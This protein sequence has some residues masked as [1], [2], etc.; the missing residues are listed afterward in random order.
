MKRLIIIGILIAV[1]VVLVAAPALSYGDYRSKD[2]EL[3]ITVKAYVA[4]STV[5]I[6]VYSY[7]HEQRDYDH[8]SYLGYI[9][10]YWGQV[11]HLAD[12]SPSYPFVSVVVA[13]M[14]KQPNGGTATVRLMP[15]DS[16]G[17]T[18][19]DHF[20]KDY[21]FAVRPGDRIMVQIQVV[22][23]SGTDFGYSHTEFTV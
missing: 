5:G 10:V 1:I 15:D 8:A 6:G 2:T 16:V 7:T 23:A 17:Y 19:G 12:V 21:K 13:K 11:L 18:Y 22:K 14:V 3:T 9:G 4:S 20:V